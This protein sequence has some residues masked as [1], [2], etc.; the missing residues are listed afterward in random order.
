VN[1][2]HVDELDRIELDDGFVWRPIRRHFGIR[3]FGVNA[4]S[5]TTAGSQV[6]ESHTELQLG[7]EEI[8]LVLRGRARF[9]IGDDEHEL[10][11]GQLVLVRDPALRR[12]AVALDEDTVVLALG[13]KPGEAYQ[14]SAWEAMFAAVPYAREERWDEAIRLHEEALAEQPGHPAL[15]Y[16]LACM[17][18]RGGRY[19]DA[20]LHLREAVEIDRKWAEYAAKDSDFAAIRAEPGFP[21]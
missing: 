9:T 18:C 5:P 4:Y 17:E 16:N 6:V 7:H 19:L 11:Q 12:G 20:L 2:A 1:V 3:A 10:R 15:L 13:G 21:A 8:Y 14:V